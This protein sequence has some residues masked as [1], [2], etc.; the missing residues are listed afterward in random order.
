MTGVGPAGEPARGPQGPLPERLG[1]DQPTPNRVVFE[2]T[3]AHPPGRWAAAGGG[4][5]AGE[6][7]GGAVEQ[8]NGLVER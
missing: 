6:Q 3:G 2:L 8:V 1:D 4:S 7:D 5:A